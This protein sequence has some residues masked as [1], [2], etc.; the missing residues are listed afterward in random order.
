MN[1]YLRFFS[2]LVCSTRALS[3]QCAAPLIDRKVAGG[4]FIRDPAGMQEID[5]DDDDDDD[6]DEKTTLHLIP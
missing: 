4:P 3:C 2:L 6:A 5:D 1:L